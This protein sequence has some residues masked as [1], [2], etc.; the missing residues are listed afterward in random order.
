MSREMGVMTYL[1]G[2]EK[3][4]I[5]G[6]LYRQRRRGKIIRIYVVCRTTAY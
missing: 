3:M 6:E 2:F 5:T 1:N 4:R